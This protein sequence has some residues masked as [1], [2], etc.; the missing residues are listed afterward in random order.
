MSINFFS[1][2]LKTIMKRL[3]FCIKINKLKKKKKQTTRNT[4]DTENRIR[5]FYNRSLHKSIKK[6]IDK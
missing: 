5:P 2:G 6:C 4:C 3:L 1:K